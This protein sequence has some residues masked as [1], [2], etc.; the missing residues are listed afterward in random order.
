MNGRWAMALPVSLVLL[1]ASLAVS[2]SQP[3]QLSTKAVSWRPD[4][5]FD[6][7]LFPAFVLA[8]ANRKVTPTDPSYIGDP[9]GVIG[10]RARA[11][12]PDTHFRLSVAVDGLSAASTLEGTLKEADKEYRV[13][14]R[15]RYDSRALMR[16]GQSYPTNVVISVSAEGGGSR[17]ENGTHPSP[18]RP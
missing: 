2:Q 1:F 18:G 9:N 8:M 4:I 16:I 3:S 6:G 11:T 17:R 7:Q 12:R 14:P 5:E 13:F 10:I 15:V